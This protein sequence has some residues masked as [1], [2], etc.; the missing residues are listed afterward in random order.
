MIAMSYYEIE[1]Q[2]LFNTPADCVVW[3]FARFACKSFLWLY[4]QPMEAGR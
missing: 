3:R 2:A 1:A 4:L